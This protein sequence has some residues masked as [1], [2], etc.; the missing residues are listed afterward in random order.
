MRS[1]NKVILMGH[2]AADPDERQTKNGNLVVNFPLA[3]NRNWNDNGEIKQ[4]TDYHRIVAWKGLAELCRKYLKSGLPLYMEGR[5]MNR[6]Y[7][8]KEGNVKFKTEIVMDDLKFLSFK[9]NEQKIQDV[10]IV[11]VQKEQAV[12]A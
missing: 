7:E 1:V 9:K 4:T 2:L 12:P 3:T 5:L 6:K 11:D 10:N 8:D